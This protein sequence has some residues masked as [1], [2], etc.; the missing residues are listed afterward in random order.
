MTLTRAQVVGLYGLVMNLPTDTQLEIQSIDSYGHAIVQATSE[1][2]A[3]SKRF[4]LP[5]HGGCEALDE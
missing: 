4:R 1:G 2:N 5:S 3:L